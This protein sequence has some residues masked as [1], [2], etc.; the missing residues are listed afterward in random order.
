MKIM[1]DSILFI[2]IFIMYMYIVVIIY[3]IKL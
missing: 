2:D 3:V 1:Y